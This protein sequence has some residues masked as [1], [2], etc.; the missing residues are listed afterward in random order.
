MTKKAKITKLPIEYKKT[1]E[2]HILKTVPNSIKQKDGTI[3]NTHYFSKIPKQL[4]GNVHTKKKK[5]KK[6]KKKQ[7]KFRLAK[8]RKDF[9]LKHLKQ[10]FIQHILLFGSFLNFENV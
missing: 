4:E 10:I 8:T 6:K 1:S 7:C 9:V 3:S 5:K 2:K